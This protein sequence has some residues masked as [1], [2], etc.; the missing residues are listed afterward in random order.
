MSDESSELTGPRSDPSARFGTA[1]CGRDDMRRPIEARHS[2]RQPRDL[3]A[4]VEH[5]AG[6]GDACKHF[7]ERVADQYALGN[8]FELFR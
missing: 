1:H 4:W 2:E 8:H 5:K 3:S 6:S 7:F